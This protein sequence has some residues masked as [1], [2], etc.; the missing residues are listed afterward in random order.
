VVIVLHFVVAAGFDRWSE[1]S[2]E[3]WTIVLEGVRRTGVALYLFAITFG[4]GTIITV[5]RFQTNRISRLQ[6][7][8]AP[9]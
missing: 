8:P 9:V 7:E 3:Q 4:L 5:L 6:A 2:I 1:A